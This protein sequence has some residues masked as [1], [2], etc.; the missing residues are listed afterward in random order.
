[1]EFERV[2][3]FC[4]EF[5]PLPGGIGNHAFHLA[6][7]LH[8]KL[9]KVEIL[10]DHRGRDTQDE[11]N[12]FDKALPFP[13][14]RIPRYNLVWW[15][16]LRRC[17]AAI[18]ILKSQ[19]AGIIIAS[20]KFQLWLASVLSFFFPKWQLIAI[21]H[22]SELGIKGSWLQFTSRMSLKR[23][24][25]RIAVSQ[26]IAQLLYDIDQNLFVT[27]IPNGFAPLIIDGTQI[28]SRLQGHPALVTVGNVS[29]R[30]GQQNV[31]NA[32]PEIVQIF[33]NVHYHILG[34]PT[35]QIAFTRLARELGVH[36]HVTFHGPVSQIRLPLLLL[37]AD[38]FVMLSE[39]LSN[40]DVEGFGIAI[41]EANHLGLPAIGSNDSGIVDAIRDKF[42]G[43]LVSQRNPHDVV[44]ALEEILFNYEKYSVQ[45]QIWTESFRWENVIQKYLDV[46]DQIQISDKKIT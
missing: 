44:L 2:V 35:E 4:S 10:T 34:I 12:K 41:L 31:I 21:I 1:M 7:S 45:A 36:D 18:N 29:Y 16:Y 24:H 19:R 32:L 25:K 38:I 42:S 23:F 26:Y 27:V 40:G 5:P 39:N 8:Q 11:E 22:G 37:G 43:R 17:L 9:I 6:R 46:F 33:P 13:V 30:K 28:P 14:F 15:T 20:G 3:L